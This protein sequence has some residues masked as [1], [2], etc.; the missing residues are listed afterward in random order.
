[1]P[2]NVDVTQAMLL[3]GHKTLEVEQMKAQIEN[4]VAE[5]NKLKDENEYFRVENMRLR[6]ELCQTGRNQLSPISIP[7]SSDS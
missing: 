4:I 2:L 1:M 7:M 3:L 6:E 5:F